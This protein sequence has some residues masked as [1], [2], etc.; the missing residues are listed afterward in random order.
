MAL[1]IYKFSTFSVNNKAFGQALCKNNFVQ[2]FVLW[3]LLRYG[4]FFVTLPIIT[5]HI[6]EQS[7]FCRH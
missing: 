2:I 1:T 6:Y 4:R 7:Q 3:E 5:L